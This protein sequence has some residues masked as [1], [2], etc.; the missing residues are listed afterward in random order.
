M[1]KTLLA[2]ASAVALTCSAAMPTQ[3]APAYNWTG[4]YIGGNIGGAWGNSD[5]KLTG[6]PTAD[7]FE[8]SG[9]VG[10]PPTLHPKGFIGGGQIGYNWQLGNLLVGAEA[11]FDS[12]HASG[13]ASISPFFIGKSG[14][15][16]VTWSSGYDWLF[17]AG[18]RLGVLATPNWLLYITGGLA[19]TRVHDSVTCTASERDCSN[20]NGLFPPPQMFTWSGSTTLTGGFFGGGI[21]TM[22]LPHWTARAEFLYAHFPDTTPVSANITTGSTLI[23]PLFSFNHDLSVFRFG[24]NYNFGGP[25]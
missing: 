8:L 6:D 5:P 11:D 13:T 2:S 12:L 25:G 9:T 23:P 15:N 10:A 16:T 20:R 24:I 17:T 3:A 1:R 14:Q 7:P 19:A 21:E 22:F 4:F 18:P